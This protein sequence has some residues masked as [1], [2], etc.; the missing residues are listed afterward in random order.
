MSG[1]L[2]NPDFNYLLSLYLCK[3]NDY[4]VQIIL[5]LRLRLYQYNFYIN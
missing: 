4:L 3:S 2:D 1:L 5:N